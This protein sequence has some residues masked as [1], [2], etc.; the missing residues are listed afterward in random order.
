MFILPVSSLN[1]FIWIITFGSTLAS[2]DCRCFP[3][4]ECWPTPP[5]WAAFNETINGR[6]IATVPIASVCR[7]DIL[8][9]YNPVK[10][11]Q[12][13][14]DWLLPETH[15]TTPSSIMAQ[16]FAN[17]SCDPFTL[18]SAQCV[19]GTYVQYAVNATSQDD[20][21]KTMAFAVA[22]NIRFVIR[23]T[24]H[25][26]FGKSTG[27]GAL[28]LWTHN[29]KDIMFLD[30]QSSHYT[31]RAMKIGAGVQV[32][33]ALEAAHAQD[34]V[35]A[36]GQCQSVGVAGGYSQGGGHSLMASQIGLSADQVLEWE[37]VTTSGQ[38]LVA[39]P[40]RNADLY[41]AL[42]GGGGGTYAA[43]LSVTLKAY[44]DVE[45]A[46]G[47]FTVSKTGN[48]GISDDQFSAIVREW[49]QNLPEL[50]D[51]G[52]AALWSFAE[53]YL[54]ISPVV[55]PNMTVPELRG[56]LNRTFQALNESGMTYCAFPP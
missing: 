55:G 16:F 42:S 31:G 23:N 54:S 19:P 35:V 48:E 18:P 39:T 38:H 37:V 3:G 29:L 40:E 52:G 12:L 26:Y 11:Q 13:Q 34:L 8:T 56:L 6:L 41:W 32:W 1:V 30:Y 5:E 28:A 7:H 10:C 2:T 51:S 20:Y 24:G 17:F 44:A 14:D 53:G 36:G 9:S 22:R 46:A 27:A 49:L 45:V 43:V 33:E 25:D 4:D 47:A 15:Y 50:V 21:R